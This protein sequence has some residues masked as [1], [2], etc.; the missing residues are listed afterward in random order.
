MRST[1][2]GSGELTAGKNISRKPTLAGAKPCPGQNCQP[3][4]HQRAS[5]QSCGEIFR[6]AAFNERMI[7]RSILT[8]N[9]AAQLLLQCLLPLT[10]GE[11]ETPDRDPRSL[12][13]PPTD[14]RCVL[15]CTPFVAVVS[16]QGDH[17]VQAQNLRGRYA[18][19]KKL[20]TSPIYV[21]GL[22][23]NRT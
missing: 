7:Q 19:A 13:Q 10:E 8:T 2:S 3:S 18:P 11:L 20:G 17:S 21:T 4:T 22:Y 1:F 9:A 12:P 15:T 14:K 6:A 23:S 5:F 16:L